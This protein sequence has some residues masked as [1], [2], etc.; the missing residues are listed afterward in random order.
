MRC[1]GWTLMAMM[2][3]GGSGCTAPIQSPDYPRD[4]AL[5]EKYRVGASFCSH[6]EL[7][8]QKTHATKAGWAQALAVASAALGTAGGLIMAA[9]LAGGDDAKSEALVTSG[10]IGAGSLAALV[11]SLTLASSSS[12][13]GTAAQEANL[14][15][16]GVG[17]KRKYDE[18]L[19]TKAIW[20][21][22]NYER[23]SE[24]APTPA[25]GGA[26]TP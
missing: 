10:A 14:S 1:A 22:A 9:S 26:S 8:A 5:G 15:M 21:G 24:Q 20:L 23:P 11:G 13:A 2:A 19:L 17:D 12:D 25:P 7:E 4:G 18:C 6:L 3:I 16:R